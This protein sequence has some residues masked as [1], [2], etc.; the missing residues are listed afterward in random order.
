MECIKFYCANIN[1]SLAK[2]AFFVSP[3]FFTTANSICKGSL[4]QVKNFHMNT[5]SGF[6]TFRRFLFLEPLLGEVMER[7]VTA[8]IPQYFDKFYTDSF[9]RKY[10]E[11]NENSPKVL[12]LDDLFFGF[13]LWLS[14]CGISIVGFLLEILIH[15]VD[16]KLRLC[17]G[18]VLILDFINKVY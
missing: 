2:L 13:S 3:Q 10:E 1:N 4:I 15:S 8:G 7:I 6:L 5:L 11:I 12:T 16:Q 18:L 17:I 14:A 9:L